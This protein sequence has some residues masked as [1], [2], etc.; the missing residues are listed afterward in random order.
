ML[1]LLDT[2]NPEWDELVST[3]ILEG[4]FPVDTDNTESR[5]HKISDIS[6]SGQS[7][8]IDV[9]LHTSFKD[10]IKSFCM[11]KT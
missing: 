5:L 3:Y 8:L 4:S 1:V 11:H 10:C 2:K 7:N 9:E 6:L